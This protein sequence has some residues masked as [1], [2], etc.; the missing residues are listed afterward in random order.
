MCSLFS[1][2]NVAEQPGMY[3]TS[4]WNMSL[5]VTS[6]LAPDCLKI[7]IRSLQAIS[8]FSCHCQTR[9]INVARTAQD[10]FLHRRVPFRKRTTVGD[11]PRTLFNSRSSIHIHRHDIDHLFVHNTKSTHVNT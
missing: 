5:T 1:F 7:Q 11:P 9:S 3:R 10:I 2:E 6:S 4:T 8:M